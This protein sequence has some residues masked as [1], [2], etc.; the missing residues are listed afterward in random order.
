MTLSGGLLSLFRARSRM[1]WNSIR[2]A[3]EQS[4][5]KLV[6]IV[7][8]AVVI[9]A[10]LFVAFLDGFNY[11]ARDAFVGLKPVV[12]DLLLSVFFLALL[13][14]LVF[15]NGIIAY[16]SLFRSEEASYLFAQPFAPWQIFGYKLSETL[17]FSSWA[18]LFLALPLIVAYGV[19]DGAPWYFYPGG[20][21]FFGVFALIPAA[22]GGIV[23]LLIARFF[24]ISPRRAL[25]AVAGVFVVVVIVWGLSLVNSY[26]GH[27]M[28]M[29]E[30]AWM[31]DTLGRLGVSKNLLLPSR[32]AC[33]GI[34]HLAHGHLREAGYRFLL[35]LS[36]GLFF[37]MVGVHVSRWIY[38]RAYHRVQALSR[39]RV[40]RGGRFYGVL[41]RLLFWTKPQMRMLIVKDVKTFVRDPVQ[42][43]Q[44]LIFF[45]LLAVYF[46][47]MRSFGYHVDSP[48]WKNFISLL[49]LV[50][51]S[52]T[53]S[54]FTCRFI[55]PLLS[56][57]G[58]RFWVLGLLPLDRSRLLYSKFW[59]A[60]AGAFLISE[61]LI[62]VSDLML[63]VPWEVIVMH[64]LT[65]LIICGGLSGLAVGL[66][67][68]YPNMREGN[69]SKIVSG[70]GGTLNLVLSIFYV[71]VM[72][73]LLA[74]PYHV[75]RMGWGIDARAN[76]ARGVVVPCS[77]IAAVV[78]VVA[79]LLPMWLG[80]RAFQRLET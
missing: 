76:L 8:F 11:M 26:R 20:A 39:R 64:S 60:F 29:S 78:G 2:S 68:L 7:V 46:L 19:S 30:P 69:P 50:V 35:L 55:F 67:A 6:V 14:L 41:E 77:L 17:V 58:R 5:M 47:N 73:G 80:V 43:S 16:G 49:N 72:T 70:F 27:M 12:V 4:I 52:L 9:W 54:T 51:T 3:R 57:E 74:V 22:L 61:G 10:G 65:V 71:V 45:G 34:Q 53:L 25:C 79:T 32:W 59:F 15:S 44:V 21:A 48:R 24:S 63:A 42:W 31:Q 36:N 13:M 66:G 38:P 40:G 18:F 1:I 75:G 62:V 37:W 23:T 56:L 33:L 28:A